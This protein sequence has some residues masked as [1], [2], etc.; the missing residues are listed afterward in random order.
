[1]EGPLFEAL[2]CHFSLGSPSQKLGSAHRGCGL[3]DIE[4]FGIDG[5]FVNEKGRTPQLSHQ[6]LQFGNSIPQARVFVQRRIISEM[7]EGVV[8]AMRQGTYLVSKV[9][10]VRFCMFGVGVGIGIHVGLYS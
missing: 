1:M 9:M 8:S 2:E 7:K 10:A 6:A 4:N 3:P 5:I